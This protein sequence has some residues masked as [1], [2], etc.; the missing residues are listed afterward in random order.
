[1]SIQRC[2]K[3]QVWK[4]GNLLYED[5]LEYSLITH[6]LNVVSFPTQIHNSPTARGPPPLELSIHVND[7]PKLITRVLEGSMSVF[8]LTSRTTLITSCVA[9]SVSTKSVVWTK[10][11]TEEQ[12]KTH[13]V[14]NIGDLLSEIPALAAN[15]EFELEAILSVQ[16][17]FQL[18][19]DYCTKV[20][21]RGL[22]LYHTELLSLAV[23]L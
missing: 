9:P 14:L 15:I 2:Y 5:M 10:P 8:P 4:P 20:V 19:S 23:L 18:N 7:K 1:M 12:K 17:V 21:Y 11:W 22:A 13:C 3:I 16:F 6:H